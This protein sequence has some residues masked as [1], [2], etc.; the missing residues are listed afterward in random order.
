MLIDCAIS[1]FNKKETEPIFIHVHPN[2]LAYPWVI[3]QQHR[4]VLALVQ[5]I[6]GFHL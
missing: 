1:G 2:P 5:R 4:N 6:I 3:N